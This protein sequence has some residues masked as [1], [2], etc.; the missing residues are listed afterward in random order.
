MLVHMKTVERITPYGST[1]FC[2]DIRLERSGKVTLVGTYIGELIVNGRLPTNLAKFAMRILYSERPGES[3]DPVELRIFL[4][5]D[6]EG[7]PT[8]AAAIPIDQERAKT[9]PPD[10]PDPLLTAIMHLE[11]APLA[12]KQEGSIKV[13]AYRGD[14]EVKMGQLVVRS[15]QPA[16][17]QNTHPA[18]G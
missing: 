15:S 7:A 2:D 11:F 8:L 18:P 9:P 3:D 5:G 16:E 4:P 13:R 14:L 1:I 10:M 6:E 12:I 17:D